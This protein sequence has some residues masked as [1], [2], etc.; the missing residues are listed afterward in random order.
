MLDEIWHHVCASVRR[1]A[2]SKTL[3]SLPIRRKKLASGCVELGSSLFLGSGNNAR[4]VKRARQR[5]GYGHGRN[6]YHNSCN[7]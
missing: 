3:Q 6:K 7:F 1:P 5:M 2:C 4:F